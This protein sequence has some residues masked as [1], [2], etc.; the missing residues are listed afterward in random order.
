MRWAG[1]IGFTLIAVSWLATGCGSQTASRSAAPSGAPHTATGGAS[2]T[3][4][5]GA[6]Q[7]GRPASVVITMPEATRGK[8]VT[9]A[10]RTAHMTASQT[11]ALAAELNQLTRLLNSLQQP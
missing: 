11:R 8:T 9:I 10:V 7:T 2:R 6:G 3:P 5:T 1:V 4:L